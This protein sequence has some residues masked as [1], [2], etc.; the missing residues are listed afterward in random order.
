MSDSD[1][2]ERQD[3]YSHIWDSNGAPSDGSAILDLS[4]PSPPPPPR[5]PLPGYIRE[6][7]HTLDTGSALAHVNIESE[8][9][10]RKYLKE[11]ARD[12]IIAKVARLKRLQTSL[13]GVF[14]KSELDYVS[15]GIKQCV[16][17]LDPEDQPRVST[18]VKI[19]DRTDM[20]N[21]VVEGGLLH[22][23][24]DHE[25]FRQI[26]SSHALLIKSTK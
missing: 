15:A 19:K 7:V 6:L 11:C 3:S 10:V 24:D 22:E 21:R 25:L 12:V 18:L 1:S 23:Q 4:S 17:T 8:F 9:E 5:T 2:S 16:A 20:L 26:I 14:S 13:S